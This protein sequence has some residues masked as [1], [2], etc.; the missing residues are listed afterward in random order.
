MNIYLLLAHPD[1]ESFNGKIADTYEAE[2]LK[3]GHTVRRQ[4]IGEMKFDPVL[5]KGYAEIQTQEPDLVEAQE[6][7]RWCSKW[8][9][10]YPVWWGSV[11]AIFKGFLDRALLPG[12]A[13]KYGEKDI[14]QTK[15]LKGRS[16]HLITTSDAPGLW[17]WW[18]YRNSDSNMMRHPVLQFCGFRPVRCTRI[19]RMKN[20]DETQRA[21]WLRKI[22]GLV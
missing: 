21:A 16:A 19:G 7:I 14:F 20:L 11:P 3:K 9:I 15:L 1:K 22:A 18:Q 10:V 13:F 5:W 17:L 12:F 4:N 6:N 8:V 2:A